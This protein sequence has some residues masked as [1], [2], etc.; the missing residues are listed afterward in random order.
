M[1][2]S[3]NSARRISLPL[4]ALSDPMISMHSVPL[5]HNMVQREDLNEK[6]SSYRLEIHP[7]I[8][9]SATRK[10]IIGLNVFLVYKTLALDL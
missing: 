8:E 6:S 2:V 7:K 5:P 1:N 10:L 4:A 9:V 3:G